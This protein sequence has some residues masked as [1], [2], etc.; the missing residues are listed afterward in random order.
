MSLKNLIVKNFMIKIENSPTVNSRQ[1]LKEAIDQMDKYKLG[2][3]SI[4]DE[5]KKLIS[6]ITDGDLRRALIKNQKPLSAILVDD[7]VKYSAQNPLTIN[8]D[9][10]LIESII[11]MNEKQIWD[12][13]VLNNDNKLTGLLHLHTAIK[14][15][16]E[17]I[18]NEW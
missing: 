18:S 1:M 4:I 3:V 12:L 17:A 10:T 13:P 14:N 9:K 15:Y 11:L 8:E 16:I 6:V 2:I 5:D 7:A